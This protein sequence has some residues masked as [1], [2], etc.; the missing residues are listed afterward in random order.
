[1]A[2]IFIVNTPHSARKKLK[3]EYDDVALWNPRL[4][5]ADLTGFG[6]KGPDAALP[7]SISRPSG[8]KRPVIHDA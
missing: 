2:D 5:Y 1:V 4:I 7:G 6:E 8:T 3:L